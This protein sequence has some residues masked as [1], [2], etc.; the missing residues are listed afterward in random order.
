LFQG[1]LRVL[2]LFEIGGDAEVDESTIVFH[3][4]RR[5]SARPGVAVQVLGIEFGNLTK[6]QL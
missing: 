5:M 2:R 4:E 1:I 3:L 6:L